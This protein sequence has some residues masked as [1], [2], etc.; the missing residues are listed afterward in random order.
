MGA[1]IF[2]HAWNSHVKFTFP[3]LNIQDAGQ[4]NGRLDQQ[5]GTNR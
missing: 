1:E 4:L 5:T 3:N 2:E